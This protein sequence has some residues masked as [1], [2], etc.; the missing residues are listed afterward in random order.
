MRPF[1][2]WDGAQPARRV[3]VQFEGG[4]VT[5]LRDAQGEELPL[6][7]LEPLP[8]GG[9][10]PAGNEDRVLVRLADVPHAPRAAS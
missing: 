5:A 2:F 6:A 9:I 3:R 4:T 7:R 10:Y 8:I 1:V